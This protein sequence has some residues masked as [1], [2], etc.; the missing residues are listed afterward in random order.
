MKPIAHIRTDF[1]EKFGIPRQ[2]GLVPGLCGRVVFLP[3][4]R[5]PDAL[6]GLE[7]YS[8]VWLLWEFSEAKRDTWS[9]TVRPPRLGGNRRM[10]VFATR[11]PFRPNPIGLSCVRLL[12]IE[13]TDLVVEGADLLDGTPIYDIKPYLPYTD[14]HPE[15]T[16]GFA[17]EVYEDRLTVIFPPDLLER[18]PKEK[19]ESALALLRGDPRPSYQEDE[20][21]IYG[22]PYAGY[23]IRFQVAG[24]TLTVVAVERL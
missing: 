22:M 13:G 24:D 8:H 21:R 20:E 5:N 19:Q 4:Y 15:A 9:P 17:G 23:D 12:A 10:G 16:A 1:P 7:G 6:R 3:A 2:S 18:L 11:S 14:A